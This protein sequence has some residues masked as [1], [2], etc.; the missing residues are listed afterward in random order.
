MPR[1]SHSSP[2]LCFHLAGQPIPPTAVLTQ[3]ADYRALQHRLRAALLKH[4]IRPVAYCLMPTQWHLIVG[5]VDPSRLRRCLAGVITTPLD[6]TVPITVTPLPA[7][8]DL[9]RTTRVV[10]RLAL[11]HRLVRRAQDWPWGSLAARL[12]GASPLPLVPAPFLE[13]RAWSDYVNA[14]EAWDS[15]HLAERPRWFARRAQGAEHGIGV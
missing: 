13:S 2:L 12:D 1:R 10:E 4:P 8:R 15:V 6:A 14:A 3:P 5:P 11:T 9:V 7:I